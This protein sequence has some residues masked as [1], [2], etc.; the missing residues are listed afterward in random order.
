M[1][2]G[3]GSNQDFDFLRSSKVINHNEY[4]K[5]RDGSGA[6]NKTYIFYILLRL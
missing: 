4:M 3:R 6:L 5:L 1:R 2:F